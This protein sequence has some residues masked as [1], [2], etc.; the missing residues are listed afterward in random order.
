MT[1]PNPGGRPIDASGAPKLMAAARELINRQGYAGV[2]IAM[3]ADAAGVGRQMVYRRWRS[4]AELVLD[5]SLVQAHR[6]A[7]DDLGTVRDTLEAFLNKVFRELEEDG[8][9]VRSLIAEAQVDDDFRANLDQRF[10]RPRSQIV[11]EIL[12][13]G[14]STGELPEELDV[15]LIAELIHGAYWYRLIVGR[16]LDGEFA[17]RLVN[18]TLRPRITPGNI[19]EISDNNE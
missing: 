6:P 14:A 4:K 12:K 11:L 13:H 3:I 17:K 1:R 8:Q 19:T 5:A 15:E 16:P 18:V 10:A 7:A 2:T 9:A